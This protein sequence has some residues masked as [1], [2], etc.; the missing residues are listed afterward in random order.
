MVFNVKKSSIFYDF[1]VVD[2]LGLQKSLTPCREQN[3]SVSKK[4]GMIYYRNENSIEFQSISKS[5]MCL[6]SIYFEEC[7]AIKGN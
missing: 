4:H 3:I 2:Q 1:N 7:Y 6:G 5:I